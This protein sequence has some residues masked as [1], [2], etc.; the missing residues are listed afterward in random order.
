MKQFVFSYLGMENAQSCHRVVIY[1]WPGGYDYVKSVTM[2]AILI[3]MLRSQASECHCERRFKGGIF[4]LWFLA[5][6]SL[7]SKHT[8]I[9]FGQ[10]VDEYGFRIIQL[11]IL[12]DKP[13]SIYIHN[14]T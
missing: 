8:G 12:R 7:S 5:L 4:T 11:L 1:P 9:L 6:L 13:I 2:T 10:A 14:P 3:V